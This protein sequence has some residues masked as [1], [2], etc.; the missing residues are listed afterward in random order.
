MGIRG[1]SWSLQ[2]PE[3]PWPSSKEILRQIGSYS[4]SLPQH[5]N[6]CRKEWWG[7][8]WGPGRSGLS[9][10]SLK[11]GYLV[12]QHHL[13][14]LSPW[15]NVFLSLGCAWSLLTLPAFWRP[16]EPF[17]RGLIIGQQWYPAGF[18]T[19]NLDGWQPT[20]LFFTVTLFDHQAPGRVWGCIKFQEP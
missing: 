8:S 13:A 11:D 4:Y 15:N 9:S 5:T 7:I 3:E 17:P 10:I 14:L 16:T 18:A 2:Q 19:S 1:D 20:V 12:S 6:S